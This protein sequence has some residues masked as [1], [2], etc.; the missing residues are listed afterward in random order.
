M[1]TGP[2]PRRV[3]PIRG[4]ERPLSA[5]ARWKEDRPHD[6]SHR[7][8]SE[9][10]GQVDPVLQSAVLVLAGKHLG[11]E[12]PRRTERVCNGGHRSL[13]G[14]PQEHSR[15]AAIVSI[16]GAIK[17]LNARVAKLAA[18]VHV[19][20]KSR[21]AGKSSPKPRGLEL[22]LAV[23]PRTKIG[24]CDRLERARAQTRVKTLLRFLDH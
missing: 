19:F 17:T 5:A 13:V 23:T 9:R 10:R 1:A 12:T 20:K 22:T 4:E 18:V 15:E 11:P 6:R 14:G 2:E 3:A 7:A 21:P 24:G 8:G 16:A